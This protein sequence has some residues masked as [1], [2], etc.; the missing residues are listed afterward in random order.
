LSVVVNGWTLL[1]HPVIAGRLTTLAAASRRARRADPKNFQSNRNVRFFAAV[2]KLIFEVIPSDPSRAEYRQGSTLGK[3]HRHWF[4]AKFFRRFRLFFR[5]DSRSRIIVY[6]W[7]NDEQTLRQSGSR[8]DPY[9]VFSR[10][11]AAGNP[12][13]DW[14]TLVRASGGLPDEILRAITRPGERE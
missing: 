11:L 5:Y 12:P 13:D 4:R 9:E 10:M 8:R 7:V 2:T 6:V 14:A 1:F 3:D